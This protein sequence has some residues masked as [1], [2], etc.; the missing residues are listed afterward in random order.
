M[1]SKAV[2][3]TTRTLLTLLTLLTLKWH[4]MPENACN[5]LQ[6]LKFSQGEGPRTPWPPHLQSRCDGPAISELFRVFL[7]KIRV[8]PPVKGSG[9]APEGPLCSYSNMPP[10]STGLVVLEDCII[11][12]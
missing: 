2:G 3:S 12:F 4:Q 11:M 8:H 1:T 7:C 5:C 6:F 9:D 10:D